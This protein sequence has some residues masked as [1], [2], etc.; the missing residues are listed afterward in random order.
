MTL[1]GNTGNTFGYTPA[2]RELIQD[3]A[4][5]EEFDHLAATLKRILQGLAPG[6]A[7]AGLDTGDTIQTLPS[8]SGLQE[9]GVRWMDGPWLLGANGGAGGSARLRP[10]QITS[11]QNDYAPEGIDHAV[12]LELQTDATRIIT[13][14]KRSAQQSRLMGVFNWGDYTI[15]FAHANTSSDARHR[16]YFGNPGEYIDLTT[17]RL[18]WWY[19]DVIRDY[20]RIFALPAVPQTSLPTSLKVS[21]FPSFLARNWYA[22][23]AS[24]GDTTFTAIGAPAPTV[25]NANTINNQATSTF[26]QYQGAAAAGTEQGLRNTGAAACQVRHGPTWFAVIRTDASIT[27]VRFWIGMTNSAPTNA[28]DLGGATKYIMFRYSTVAGDAGWVGVARDGA[29]QSV[30]AIAGTI[31]INT[32]YLLKIRMSD[33][34]TTAYF[35]VN[36]GDEI[37]LTTNLPAGTTTLGWAISLFT[38]ENVAKSINISRMFCEFGS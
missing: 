34:G 17:G 22:G 13:G 6:A 24:G 36:G 8:D 7:E 37:P 26:V 4:V 33:D 15:R 25:S 32:T 21:A 14:I 1:S 30:T 38:T 31:A 9:T 35:S 29:A 11:D 27:A 16:F 10:P 18:I 2:F 28:D 19:Y 5:R 23:R 3:S 20:W 12:M